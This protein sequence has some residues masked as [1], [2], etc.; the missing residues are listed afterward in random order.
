MSDLLMSTRLRDTLE[1]PCLDN[2]RETSTLGWR[3]IPCPGLSDLPAPPSG[4][5]GWPWTEGTP[6]LPAVM[7]DGSAW[8]RISIVTPSCNQR[9]FLE[10]AIRSILLQGYPNLHRHGRRLE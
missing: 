9:R 7:P 5:T 10:E 8:P 1:Y 4:R 3:S 6:A 2:C